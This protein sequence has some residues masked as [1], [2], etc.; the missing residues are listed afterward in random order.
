MFGANLKFRKICVQLYVMHDCSSSRIYFLKVCGPYF[1]HLG[2][3]GVVSRCLLYG[4]S[5]SSWWGSLF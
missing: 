3:H 4:S 1:Y 5:C 2:G